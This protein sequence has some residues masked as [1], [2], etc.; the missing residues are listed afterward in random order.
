MKLFTL[1]HATPELPAGWFRLGRYSWGFS[2]TQLPPMFSEREG[3][4]K[5][6]FCV[7]RWRVFFLRRYQFR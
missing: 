3:Y 5:P 2:W 7:G 4:R 6:L 1:E